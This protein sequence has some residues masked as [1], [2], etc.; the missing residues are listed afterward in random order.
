ME[1]TTRDMVGAGALALVLL[2]FVL[3]L[4]VAALPA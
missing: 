2:A 1:P 3:L 4:V